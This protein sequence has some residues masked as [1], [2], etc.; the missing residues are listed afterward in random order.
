MID[1]TIQV[2]LITSLTNI[3]Y[4]IIKVVSKSACSECQFCCFKIKRN[5]E[6][7]EKSKEFEILHPPK[8][9]ET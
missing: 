8:E 2:L 6:I 1:S 3:V 7:E 9:P 5:V 4:Q